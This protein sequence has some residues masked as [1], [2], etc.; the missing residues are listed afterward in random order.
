MLDGISKGDIVKISFKS[1]F[2]SATDEIYNVDFCI[3]TSSYIVVSN[4]VVAIFVEKEDISKIEKIG[5]R[6]I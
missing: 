5:K 3:P 2:V 1:D 4:D 6:F